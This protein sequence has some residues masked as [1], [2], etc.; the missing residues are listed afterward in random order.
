[1]RSQLTR[2][3]LFIILMGIWCPAFSGSIILGAN[4][5]IVDGRFSDEANDLGLGFHAGYEFQ[6]WKNW[7]FGALFEYLDGWNDQEN[8]NIT[9]DMMYD[10]KSLY[11]TARPNNWP[12]MFK[13][14]IV[15]ADY[16]VL[17]QTVPQDIR[18]VS[19]TGYGYGV[20]LVLGSETFRFEILDVKRIKI[21]SDTFTTYGITVGILTN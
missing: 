7:Q 18:E 20:S 9:G 2:N 19:D 3:V 21:G 16:K 12:I 5:D 8:L 13:V 4:L 14:G 1:V 17:Q 10:S 6:E 11:A 15:D